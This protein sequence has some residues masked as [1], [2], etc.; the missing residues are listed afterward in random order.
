MPW[1]T[2]EVKLRLH[3]KNNIEIFKKCPQLTLCGQVIF[4]FFQG[5]R[6]R[7]DPQISMTAQLY[8]RE[9]PAN[10]VADFMPDSYWLNS[11]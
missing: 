6:K 3:R 1:L 11:L 9:R 4:F 2:P 10:A 5:N 7:K 8:N